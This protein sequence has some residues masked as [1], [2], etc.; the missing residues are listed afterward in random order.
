MKAYLDTCIVSGFA[1]PDLSTTELEALNHNEDLCE[2]DS[3]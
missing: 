3:Q 1:K 2:M